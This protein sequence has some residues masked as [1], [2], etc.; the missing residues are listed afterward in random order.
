MSSRSQGS[1]WRK[2]SRWRRILIRW[3]YPEIFSLFKRLA[4]L[5]KLEGELRGQILGLVRSGQ[6]KDENIK[7]L[8]NENHEYRELSE[9]DPKTKL[10][11]TRGLESQFLNSFDI[12]R[13]SEMKQPIT[14]AFVIVDLDNFKRLNDEVGHD[15][16]D[17]ALLVVT[18]LLQ[19][20]FPRNTDPKCRWGGD[21]FVVVLIGSDEERVSVSAERFRR[22]VESDPR[23]IFET[24]G[25]DK[26]RV[27][28]SIGITTRAIGIEEHAVL[29]KLLSAEIGRTDAALREAKKS[30][31][32]QI[33]LM[34]NE[35]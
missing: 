5:E 3:L 1:F 10:L 34:K 31:K 9:R 8:A 4:Q 22:D 27:T 11:N 23:L 21:E 29:D 13:R 14:A 18:E 30:G 25:G 24:P 17:T 19:L 2:T 16:G 35:I 6:Q 12:A 7:R 15:Y 32:N 26:I 28:A 33:H 20:C